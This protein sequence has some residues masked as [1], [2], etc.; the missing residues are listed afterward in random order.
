[1]EV[2]KH[3]KEHFTTICE[4][5]GCE[6]SYNGKEVKVQRTD[7]YDYSSRRI[8]FKFIHSIDC[9]ECNNIIYLRE[10]CEGENAE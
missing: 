6:F 10:Y 4:I 3:G 2:I 9:P 5:C 1:M 8:A 7:Y